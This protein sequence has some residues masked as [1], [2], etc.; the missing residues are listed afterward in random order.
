MG[1]RAAFGFKNTKDSPTLW[2]YSHWGGSSQFKDLAE[3]LN[4]ARPR[5]DQPDYAT[6]ICISH[7]IG[8]QWASET[9][10]GIEVG[11]TCGIMLDW[12]QS[13]VV[14]WERKQV[15]I[16]NDSGAPIGESLDFDTFIALAHA[17]EYGEYFITA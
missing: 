7:I 15:V 10:Y 2:L 12:V 4:A 6:R 16:V 3:A 5:W 8:D 17:L 11:E 1:D 9:G 13:A 14:D